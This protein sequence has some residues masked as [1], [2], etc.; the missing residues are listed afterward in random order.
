M[1]RIDTELLE[2]VGL[3]HLPTWEQNLLLKHLYETLEQRVGINLADR[4][5]NKQLDEFEEFFE[6]E[7][8]EGAFRW[9]ETN[10][11][12][13]SVMVETEF[14]GLSEELAEGASAILSYSRHGRI[15]ALGQSTGVSA[16]LPPAPASDRSPRRL[17]RG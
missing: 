5:T 17:A 6:R 16:A 2:S 8:D 4:M 14:S 9:L 10:F 11:P 12:D 1:I 13:Y 3:D 7:D 15:H